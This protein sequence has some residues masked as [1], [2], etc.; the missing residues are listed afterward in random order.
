MELARPRVMTLWIS[1]MCGALALS[2]GVAQTPAAT[3]AGFTYTLT[4]TS[5]SPLSRPGI[6]GGAGSQ[7]YVAY[8]SI[9]G[10]RGRMDIVDGGVPELF[11]K[12]DYLL[13]DSAEVVIVHPA[14]QEF[15][16]LTQQT[17]AS[18]GQMDTSAFNLTISDEKVEFDSIGPGDTISTFPTT[19]YRLTLAFNMD[20]DLTVMRSRVGSEAITDYWVAAIPGMAPNPLLR[21]NGISGGVPGMLR[22]LSLRVDSATA[23]MGR[24]IVLRTSSTTRINAG[25][26]RVFESHN[27]SVVSA[28]KHA[29]V[30]KHSL[31][32]PIQ[33]RVASLPGLRAD[34]L[35]DGAKWK[36]PPPSR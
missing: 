32:V 28:I 12:G 30:D 18:S 34:S 2:S 29:A 21:S 26:G 6:T 31:I 17:L 11:A 19:R 10:S 4:V 25:P 3:P 15:V 33:Y 23:R 13:F 24:A 7:S 35:G 20:L 16:L 14:K 22:S 9:L 36:A 27:S 5:Q 1:L 8:A